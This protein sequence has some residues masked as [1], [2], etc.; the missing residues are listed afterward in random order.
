MMPTLRPI[1][2]RDDPQATELSSENF[3]L[4]R[5]LVKAQNALKSQIASGNVVAWPQGA[6]RRATGLQSRAGG[7]L[8][9]IW[10]KDLQPRLMAGGTLVK[11]LMDDGAMSVVYAPSNAGKSFFCLDLAFH[12]AMGWNWRGMPIK[13]RGCVIYIAAEGG[14]GFTNRVAALKLHHGLI[15][16]ADIPLAVLPCPVDLLSPD[17]D[18]PRIVEMTAEV[19]RETGLPVVLVVIDTLS[20][21]LAGGDENGP[22]DMTGFVGN[23]DRIRHASPHVMIVHHAG[24]DLAKGAR[25]HSSLRA[26][27][28]TEIELAPTGNGKEC[29]ATVTK[30]RD[31]EGGDVFR[32]TLKGVVLGKDEDGDPVSSAVVEHLH[33]APA[34]LSGSE[35]K[36]VAILATLIEAEG[37]PLEGNL[38][39]AGTRGIPL[40][41]WAAE[42]DKRGLSEALEAKSRAKVFRRAVTALSDKG[43]VR[44][45]PG[46]IFWVP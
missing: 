13:K 29:I 19:E 25:G 35:E 16:G 1:V 30:Q 11:G 31:L 7:D 2:H 12:I 18:T 9:L 44:E 46:G 33:D 22:K 42:C 39:P 26:A 17:A 36:A 21:A 37:V 32:F 14:H 24:K 10:A 4:R 34:K 45:A 23:I 38:L 28:D 43:A 15:D 41:R 27:T 3:T 8:P 20:R 6:R 5:E 40:D